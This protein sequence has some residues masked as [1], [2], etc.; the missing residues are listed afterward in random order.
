MKILCCGDSWTAGFGVK[1]HQAWPAVL[2][3]LTGHQVDVL[4]NSGA[5]N[6]DIQNFYLNSFPPSSQPNTDQHYDLIIFCW[7]GVTRNRIEGQVFEFSPAPNTDHLK[8]KRLNYF[9]NKSLN[10]LIDS[11]QNLMNE[12]D[13]ADTIKKIHFSVFGDR[14]LQK[15][16]NFYTTSFLEFLAEH[17]NAKFKYEIPIFE[18]GWLSGDNYNLVDQFAKLYFSKD[19]LKAIVEREDIKPGKYFLD[20]GHPNVRGHKLWAKYIASII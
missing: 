18:F 7:S 15:K 3:K 12:V 8:L 9:K 16:D 14:P 6:F 10:D 13:S 19:W 2:Q 17:Q 5:T 4:A 1:S 20:C 11:W